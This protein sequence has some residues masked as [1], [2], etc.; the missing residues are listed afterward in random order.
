MNQPPGNDRRAVP[1]HIRDAE[2]DLSRDLPAGQESQD[3]AG[4]RL[5]LL[6]WLAAVAALGAGLWYFLT[7]RP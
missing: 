2:H 3:S 5:R 4:R 6:A 7:T 1:R